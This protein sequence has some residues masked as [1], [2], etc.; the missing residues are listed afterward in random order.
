MC[1]EAGFNK[2]SK[3]LHLS[4]PAVS[5]QVKMLEQQL[6]VRLFERVGRNVVITPEGKKLRDYCRRFFSEFAQVRSQ[7]KEDLTAIEPLRIASVSGRSGAFNRKE[8]TAVLSSLKKI[9]EPF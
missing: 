1:E 4:Q 9:K 2:A 8:I 5:Y 7:F 6:G 3:K